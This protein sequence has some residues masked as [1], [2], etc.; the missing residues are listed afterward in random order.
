[1][2]TP[3][4]M[5]N[6]LA[7]KLS[8]RDTLSGEERA[9]LDDAISRTRVLGPH[10][11]IV[12]EGDRP[13]DSTLVLEGFTCRYNLLGDGKRQI[14]ALHVTGDFV[15]LHS[16]PLKVMDHGVATLSPCKIAVVPHVRLRQIT[17]SYAHLTRLLW[18]ITLMDGSIHRQWIVAMGR[19]PALGQLAHLICE[20][21]R[22]LQTVGE[23]GDLRLRLPLTQHDLA[24]TLGL[25][26]VHVNR[27]IQELRQDGLLAWRGHDVEI[28]DWDGLVAL[29]EF[30]EGYL[31]L[32]HEPR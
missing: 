5:N 1:M 8:Q 31:H 25:T 9:V 20:L 26:P 4:S 7:L 24:D 6:P 2:T 29:A 28:L 21:Y 16:F 10:E 32:N 15:D 12:R 22:R 14:T 19:K 17:E 13:T 30:D 23:A 18:L 11:D 3:G 27:V